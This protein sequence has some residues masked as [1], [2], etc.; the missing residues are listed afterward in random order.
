MMKTK[1]LFC[2]VLTALCILPLYGC[3]SGGS[4]EDE[5]EAAR[6]GI[7]AGTFN[8]TLTVYTN[9]WSNLSMEIPAGFVRYTDEELVSLFGSGCLIERAS[10]ED[11]AVVSE[12]PSQDGSAQQNTKVAFLLNNKAALS[13][14]QYTFETVMDDM[15]EEAYLL[16]VEGQMLSKVPNAKAN[17]EEASD[18]TLAGETYKM[19]SFTIADGATQD[20]YVKKKNG[21]MNVLIFVYPPAQKSMIDGIVA[22]IQTADAA[23]VQTQ[24]PVPTATPAAATPSPLPAATP[25]ASASPA[26]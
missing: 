7:S 13:N 19:M 14:I 9:E 17:S 18:V 20:I 8:D 22:S 24:T 11:D 23:A 25:Q 21:Y 6:Q 1:R 3:K 12:S 4:S 10:E 5:L 26:A 16:S 15:D 2:I